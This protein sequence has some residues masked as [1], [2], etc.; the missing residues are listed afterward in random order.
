[1]KAVT[2]G[3]LESLSATSKVAPQSLPDLV[4]LLGW[5]TARGIQQRLV[6]PYPFNIPSE[7][8]RDWYHLAGEIGQLQ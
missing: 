8:D 1:M 5:A 3:L 4:L 2:A 6:Y 7:D